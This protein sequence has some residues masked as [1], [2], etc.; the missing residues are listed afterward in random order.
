VKPP[1]VVCPAGRGLA[2]AARFRAGAAAR[3]GLAALAL[4]VLFRVGRRTFRA[5]RLAARP[6]AVLFTR[7]RGAVLRLREAAL[8]RVVRRAVLLAIP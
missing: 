8:A 4:V 1:S 7:F 2:A 5:E 3:L 6:R